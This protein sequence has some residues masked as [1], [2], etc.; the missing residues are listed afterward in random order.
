MCYMMYHT[1]YYSGSRLDTKNDHNGKAYI[2]AI[3]YN[4]EHCFS[5]GINRYNIDYNFN[6]IHAEVNAV[7]NL[8]YNHKLRQKKINMIVYR[9]NRNKHELCNA[10][11]CQNCLNYIKLNLK[12]K[13]YRLKNNRIYYTDNNGNF[14]YIYLKI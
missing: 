1:L 4:K 6:T 8:K 9:I 11:P 14:N 10:K 12:R 13:N 2:G 5:Y 7:N 3:I